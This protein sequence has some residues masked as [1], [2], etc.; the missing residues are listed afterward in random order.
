MFSIIFNFPLRLLLCTFTFHSATNIPVQSNRNYDI[1][2]C[3]RCGNLFVKNKKVRE[4][5]ARQ[6]G[7]E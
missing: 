6:V 5:K 7:V 1:F 2:A 4:R 3:K